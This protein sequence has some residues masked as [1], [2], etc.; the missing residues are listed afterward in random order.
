VWD[1]WIIIALVLWAA[2]G[3]LGGRTGKYYT[4]TQN[5][6]ADDAAESEV[7]ARLRAPTGVRLHGITLLLFVVLLLDMIFKPWA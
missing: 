6:A 5:L 2:I 3:G 7:I 1:A 4:E